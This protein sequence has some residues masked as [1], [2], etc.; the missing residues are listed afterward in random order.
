MIRDVLVA[1]TILIG[2]AAMPPAAWSDEYGKEVEA[3]LAYT[4]EV[5]EVSPSRTLIVP[6]KLESHLLMSL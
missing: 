6:L 5:I 4:G 2:S 1:A 3:P